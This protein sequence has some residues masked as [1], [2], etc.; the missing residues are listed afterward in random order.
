MF[1]MELE[2]LLRYLISEAERARSKEEILLIL[3]RA[4]D[5][6]AEHNYQK[7]R[8]EFGILL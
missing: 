3:Y 8:E 7:L 5:L 2:V 4:Y 1:D 6:V